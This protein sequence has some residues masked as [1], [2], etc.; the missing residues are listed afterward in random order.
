MLIWLEGLEMSIEE[1]NKLIEECDDE[2]K[3][4]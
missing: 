2:R 3:N 4:N 1:I